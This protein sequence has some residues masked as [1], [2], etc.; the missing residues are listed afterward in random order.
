MLTFGKLLIAVSPI[1]ILG[2]MWLSNFVGWEKVFLVGAKPF[3]L[4]EL[5][6]ILLLTFLIPFIVK[7]KNTNLS[8]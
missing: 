3:L 8:R 1:Y 2:M 4:A 5:F 6:K 7:R